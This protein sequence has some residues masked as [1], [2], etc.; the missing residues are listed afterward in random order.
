MS[1]SGT[2]TN[3]AP[4]GAA[5]EVVKLRLIGFEMASVTIRGCLLVA[6]SLLNFAFVFISGVDFIRFISFRA[7]YHNITGETTLCQGKNIY[8]QT[9]L[10][11]RYASVS[12]IS[13]GTRLARCVF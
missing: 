13:D 11:K 5:V 1:E 10:R 3:F 4:E 9:C 2:T 12:A 7:I 6:A 8:S